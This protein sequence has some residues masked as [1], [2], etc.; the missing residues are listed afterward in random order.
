[1]TIRFRLAWVCWCGVSLGCLDFRS[2]TPTFSAPK[3]VEIGPEFEPSLPLFPTRPAEPTPA[4]APTAPSVDSK[5][6]PPA[7]TGPT[8]TAP[9]PTTPTKPS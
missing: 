6:Q 7:S 4:Q 8:Q 1:M 3:L 9:T 2:P 5:P